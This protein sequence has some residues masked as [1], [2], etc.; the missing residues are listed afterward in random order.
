MQKQDKNQ[1]QENPQHCLAD[2]CLIP[3]QEARR[4]IEQIR[5][6]KPEMVHI[7]DSVG[8]ITACEVR[9]VSDCPSTDASLKDGFAVVSTDIA[10][11]TEEKPVSLQVIGTLT[12]GQKPG[13]LRVTTG[14]T[15]RV[16]TGAVI[17]EGA[18]AVLTS[19]F[20]RQ[21]ADSDRVIIFRDA[22]SGRN[23]LEHGRDVQKNAVIVRAGTR[24]R[25]THIGLLAAA[26]VSGISVYRQPRI[27]IVATGSELVKPGNP[28]GPGQVAASNLVTL[29][30]ALRDLG[31]DAKPVI[32]HDDL[33]NLQ[34][35]MLPLLEQ[36]DVMLTCGGVL[37][38]DKDLTMRAMDLLEVVPVFRR[39]RVG[40]GKGVCFG[41]FGQT[42][43]FNLP[44][45]PPSNHI[46][47]LLLALPGIQRLAGY[48]GQFKRKYKAELT[49]PLDGQL[50][51]SEIQYGTVQRKQEKLLVTPIREQSR[52]LAMAAAD[53]LIELTD[54]QKNAETGESVVIWK[55]R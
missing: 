30:A 15:V 11:A 50:G 29:Q 45:G 17:P 41:R 27:V 7:N 42:L 24:L 10:G 48:K 12:A 34:E 13:D 53:C 37:D 26:G 32:I 23:I 19:E 8:R 39:V 43:I 33:Q 35:Q 5:P 31:M 46:A 40:P 1:R 18:D 49:V 21:A 36:Y 51:W 52:L 2:R 38:G 3:L 6:L 44:G 47:F 55:I 22:H 16:M 9:A 54:T 14:K 20:S 25:A 4:K 28:I